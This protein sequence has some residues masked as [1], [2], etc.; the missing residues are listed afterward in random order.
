[1]RYL[2]TGAASGIGE[3]LTRQL[4]ARGDSV[5]GVDMDRQRADRLSAELTGEPGSIRFVVGDITAPA[6]RRD[7]LQ[8]VSSEDAL[9]GVIHSAGI[10]AVGRFFASDIDAQRKVIEVNLTAPLQLTAGLLAGR[11]LA[12]GG[13]LVF[14]SSLSH[15]TGYPGAAVYAATKDGLASYARSLSVALAPQRIHVLTVYPGPTRTPHAR[16]YSPDNSREQSRMPAQ[17]VASEILAAIARRRRILI[18]GLGNR[19]LA[20]LGR[21]WPQSMEWAMRRAILDKLAKG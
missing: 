7:L 2:I 19:A 6:C 17:R 15:Y 9:K 1:M 11:C 18:P 21:L 4:V 16:R 14:L 10:S 5:L 13:S 12:E 8:Q 3:A 20:R